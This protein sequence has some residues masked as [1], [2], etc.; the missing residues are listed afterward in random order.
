[1][2][3]STKKSLAWTM[4]HTWIHTRTGIATFC[5]GDCRCMR[6]MKWEMRWLQRKQRRSSWRNELYAAP[7]QRNTYSN[8]ITGWIVFLF[9]LD[10]MQDKQGTY[11]PFK[12]CNNS[13][14]HIIP[15]G[16]MKLAHG[17]VWK[18]VEALLS[19]GK[20]WKQATTWQHLRQDSLLDSLLQI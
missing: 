11:S 1:M 3:W 15:E 6:G 8:L 2:S 17:K 5:C 10:A 12:S 16:I 19:K 20:V 14:C 4:R 13:I 18:H 9:L 7:H